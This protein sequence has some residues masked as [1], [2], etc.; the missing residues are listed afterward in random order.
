MFS[1]SDRPDQ[2]LSKIDVGENEM[3]QP[4]SEAGIPEWDDFCKDFAALLNPGYPSAVSLAFYIRR[5]L[6]QF[7][8]LSV[9]EFDVLTEVFLRAYNLIVLGGGVVI[10][11]PAAW[12]RRTAFNHIRELSRDQKRF[13]PLE[14][15]IPSEAASSPIDHLILQAD[16]AILKRALQSLDP[17]EQR[18]LTLKIIDELSWAEI[19]ILLAGEG[20]NFSEDA[21]R[22]QK[23]RALKHLRRIY[24]ALKPLSELERKL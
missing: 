19:R 3:E 24:H 23:E 7:N 12:V 17:D 18:L 6:R 5:T 2:P 16:I 4:R 14:I 11:Y 15:D 22:K 9:T 21:L 13:T 8:L 20:Q 1:Q 10:R